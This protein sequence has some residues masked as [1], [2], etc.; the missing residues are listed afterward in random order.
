MALS[1]IQF[2][3]ADKAFILEVPTAVYTGKLSD[4][5]YEP[6][7]YNAMI[8]ELRALLTLISYRRKVR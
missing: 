6:K 8:D 3:D 2:A 1:D 4:I 5:L 7:S